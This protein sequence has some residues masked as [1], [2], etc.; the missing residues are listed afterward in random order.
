MAKKQI[1]CV[2]DDIVKDS[3]CDWWLLVQEDGVSRNCFLGPLSDAQAQAMRVIKGVVADEG[4]TKELRCRRK[5][6]YKSDYDPLPDYQSRPV[7]RPA[8]G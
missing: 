1:Q 6:E 8:C 4:A 5:V 3:N 7:F 2:L